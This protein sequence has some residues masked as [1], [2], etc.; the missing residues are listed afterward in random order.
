MKNISGLIAAALLAGAISAPALAQQQQQQ[1]QNDNNMQVEQQACEG[2]VYSLCGQAIPDQD[3]I[4]HCL[5]KKWS[6]VSHKCRSAM[7]S[8]GRRHNGGASD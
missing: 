7:A 4:Q 1:M 3:R 2:D 5:R 6:K 8:Y